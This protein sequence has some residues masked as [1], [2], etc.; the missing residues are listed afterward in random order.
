MAI[1]TINPTTGETLKVFKPL[2]DGEIAAKVELAQQSFQE[3]RQTSFE[4]RSQWLLQAANILEQEKADF[5]KIMTLEMGKTLKSAIA[6]VEKCALVCRYYAEN[7]AS[8]LA[9]VTVKTDAS[10][11]FIKYQ[12]LGV[13]LA[14]MPWNFPFWQVFRFAAPALMA[15]NVGLLKHASN[16]PQCALA[17]EDIFHR[18]GFPKGVFQTLLIGATKVADLMADDRIKAATLTGSEPAGASLAVASGK[19]IKKTVLELGGSDP[20]I[21]LESADLEL[22][23]A[24]AVTARMINNG[25]SCI[26]AKR[27]IVADQIADE[28]EKM[29]LAKFQTLKIGDP[30]ADDTDIGPL[31]TPD[32]LQDLENQVKIAVENGAKVLT[33]GNALKDQPGNFY[34]PTIIIDIPVE[35]P[36]AKEEFFGPVALL[37]RVRDINEAIKLA[38][39][40]PFGLGASAWTNNE[41]EKNRLIQEIEAGAVFINGMVKSDP[42]LP[43]GG[44]KRSGYG[45]ELSIQGIHEFVN[46]K[47][48]WMR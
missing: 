2:E 21:V 35:N 41:A 7:A 1:A 28:F 4:E 19:Q 47:T 14:V 25:Q 20:F 40:I 38:N 17:I 18:A 42:R 5:A 12:P 8:F 31:A 22:A 9:D 29:L 6:E 26:A 11:S 24:T 32:I 27:F 45:R 33:G 44:I 37:F 16:V 43:F 15:G 39:D 46:I 23:V 34:P 13:I 36:I 48:V 3:Y 10:H 30:L